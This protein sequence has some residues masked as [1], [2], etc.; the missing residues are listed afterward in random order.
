MNKFSFRG[1]KITT[2]SFSFHFTWKLYH[3][4]QSKHAPLSTTGLSNW[5]FWQ[6]V[7]FSSSTIKMN[8]F[9]QR[10]NWNQPWRSVPANYSCTYCT[11]CALCSRHPAVPGRPVS[12]SIC[13]ISASF[14][15]LLVHYDRNHQA[16]VVAILS[17][18]YWGNARLGQKELFLF[19]ASSR[20]WITDFHQL[21]TDWFTLNAL[22]L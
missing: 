7:M 4:Q 21:A 10:M 15:Y 20:M 1:K 5:N 8:G 12:I 11:F 3:R 2:L 9:A 22:H 6:Q 19:F 17:P 13:S 16:Q 14:S 18:I